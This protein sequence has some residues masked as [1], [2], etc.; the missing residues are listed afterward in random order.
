M[1]DINNVQKAA[2]QAIVRLCDPE[3]LGPGLCARYI[4]P[5]LICLVGIPNL[6]VTGYSNNRLTDVNDLDTYAVDEFIMS[7]GSYKPEMM[8]ATRA[9]ALV[10]CKLGEVVTSEVVLQKIFVCIIPQILDTS[11]NSIQ[12]LASLMEITFLLSGILAS[13]SPEIVQRAYLQVL[14]S[15]SI[16]LYAN[17]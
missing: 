17:Y 12:Y 11:A 16:L 9:V 1:D 5:A 7:E 3:M 15:M 4:V 6:A 2:V 14:V 13:L 8:F 10:C